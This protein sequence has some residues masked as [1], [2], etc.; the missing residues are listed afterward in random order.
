MS[1]A[2]RLVGWWRLDGNLTDASGNGNHGTWSGTPA[3]APG[4]YGQGALGDGTR[5]VE[6]PDLSGHLGDDFTVAAF[7]RRD[8]EGTSNIF[9]KLDAFLSF[10]SLGRLVIAS[11]EETPTVTSSNAFNPEEVKHVT[12]TYN[13]AS[14]QFV[15]Y[16]DAVV[17][18]TR[19][20]A[21]YPVNNN[22]WALMLRRSG[23]TNNRLLGLMDNAMIYNRALSPSEIK[24]LYAL[25]SPL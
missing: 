4:V 17:V 23:V 20:D 15:L 14:G 6:L 13:R 16:L 2:R 22:T 7:V 1:I 25:G 8:G 9:G 3:Y 12:L 10:A 24:T 18:L 11:G 21:D 5:H 19:I